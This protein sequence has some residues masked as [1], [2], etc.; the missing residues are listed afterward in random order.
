MIKKYIYIFFLFFSFSCVNNKDN[1]VN[2]CRCL[3]EPGDSN[4]IKNN[5][6]EC[7]KLISFEIGVADWKKINFS[8]NKKLSNAWDEMV[9][10][11]VNKI[12]KESSNNISFQDAKS[13]IINRCQTIGQKLIDSKILDVNQSDSKLYYFISQSLEH[14]EYYCLMVVSS[15]KLE[16]LGNV[17][18]GKSE[19]MKKFNNK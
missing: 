5:K 1:S 6:I 3:N 15:N 12:I 4:W 7:D 16:L 19:I 13:F 2:V 9:N 18:C 14:T 8:S 17:E 10:K 11:C